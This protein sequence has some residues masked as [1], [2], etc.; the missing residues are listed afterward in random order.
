[1]INS[2]TRLFTVSYNKVYS[3]GCLIINV[4]TSHNLS[5]A[6]VWLCNYFQQQRSKI[7]EPIFRASYHAQLTAPPYTILTCDCQNDTF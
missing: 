2:Y 3:P 5:S 6:S 4:L 7:I 1:M